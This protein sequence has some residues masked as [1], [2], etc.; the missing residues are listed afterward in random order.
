MGLNREDDLTFAASIAGIHY[1]ID[2]KPTDY[3]AKEDSKLYKED[4][5]KFPNLRSG[6][7]VSGAAFEKGPHKALE[8]TVLEI[9]GDVKDYVPPLISSLIVRYSKKVDQ[10]TAAE[11]EAEFLKKGS[12]VKP[13]TEE[14]TVGININDSKQNFTAEILSGNKTIETRD[15]NSLKSFIGQEVGLIRTGKGKA[16]VVGYATVG[17]PV[18]YNNRAEFKKDQSKHLVKTGSDYDIRTGKTKYGYPLTNVRKVS[19]FPVTS[20]GIV[21]RKIDTPK[22]KV[23]QP[24]DKVSVGNKKFASGIYTRES[25]S[26]KQFVSPKGEVRASKI[27]MRSA[28]AHAIETSSWNPFAKWTEKT[29]PFADK[30]LKHMIAQ[31]TLPDRLKFHAL[32]RE[33]KGTIKEAEDA[34]RALYDVL[35]DTKQS[36]LIFKYFTTKGANPRLITDRTERAAAVAAKEKIDAIGV[37]LVKK[38]LMREKTRQEHESAYLPQVYLKYLMG[39]DNFRRA[40]TRGGVNIDQGYLKARKDI[41]EGVKKLILGEI[42]DPAYL[43]SK[44]IS[45][46]AKDMAILDWLGHIATNPNWVVPKSMVSFDTLGAMKKTIIDKKL[47]KDLLDTLDIKDTKAVKVSS[48]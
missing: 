35:K 48:Y 27:M 10:P 30:L 9:E 15:S 13:D 23:G 8:G 22:R 36:D 38:G 28:A 29:Q 1:K 2:G 4:I 45:V 25:I 12:K 37:K 21:S 43:A 44:A 46:P 39:Q 34:G 19:P 14:P 40:V 11:L 16:E 41:P 3:T 26:P 47:S 6:S 18:V 5:K 42:K 20:K 24:S 33:V 17:E 31:G 7:F 32:R